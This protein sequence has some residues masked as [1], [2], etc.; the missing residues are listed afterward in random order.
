MTAK[1]IIF[2][3]DGTLLDTA[4]DLT[5]ALNTLLQNHKKPTLDS[6][7]IRSRINLGG[8]G[9]IEFAF[10]TEQ[11]QTELLEEF[12]TLYD[13]V[14]GTYCDFFPGIKEYLLELNDKQQ[15]WAIATN[16]HERFAK[17][18]IQQFS[19]LDKNAC[20]VCGDTVNKPKP[21]PA[22]LIHACEL[23]NVTPQDCIYIGD[24][25]KDVI[26]SKAC[27]MNCIVALFG[28]IPE[29]ADPNSWQAYAYADSAF[30][31]PSIVDTIVE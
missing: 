18:L 17:P 4:P 3:L 12:L 13:N 8:Q 6:N 29:G 9:L 26:A 27:N 30:D 28:Y 24:A 22:M 16:K 19:P 14:K 7:L 2:D 20:L 1:T 11:Y 31:L 21:D 25:E 23:M 5:Y 10:G 15:T